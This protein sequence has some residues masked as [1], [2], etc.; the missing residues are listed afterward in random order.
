MEKHFLGNA[1]KGGIYQIRNTR[2]NKIYI[3]STNNFKKRAYQHESRL[4][5]GKHYNKYLL[6]AWNKWGSDNFIFEVVEVI[7]GDKLT[8]TIREEELIKEQVELDAWNVCYNL[9]KW[10]ARK[11]G[12]YSFKPEETKSKRSKLM[13]KKWRS[14]EYRKKI[15]T[16][17]SLPETKE[18]MSKRY[19][20]R[21]NSKTK[22]EQEEIINRLST[23]NK[24]KPLSK[25]HR[26]KIGKGRIGKHH[27]EETKQKLRE[28]NLGKII[29]KETRE[30]MS[31]SRI[32]IKNPFA[33]IYDGIKLISPDGTIYTK[34]ECLSTFA[35]ENN[36]CVAHLCSLLSG[37]RKQHKGW[38]NGK[39]TY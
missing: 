12:P 35:K 9:S 18:A 24:N 26:R 21:W 10:A 34:I 7:E 6:A 31:K 28:K 30:K 25:E 19:R 11:D 13:K 39:T 1:N 32:G 15:A 14:S 29:S 38:V 3:G 8:R 2:T 16:Y 27:S 33:K 4:N 17:M 20:E 5:A 23:T 36:L 22:E 37:K